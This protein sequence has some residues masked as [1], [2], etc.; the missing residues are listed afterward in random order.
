MFE[1]DESALWDAAYANVGDIATWCRL[2]EHLRATGRHRE[3]AGLHVIHESLRRQ[4]AEAFARLPTAQRLV[5]VPPGSDED[6]FFNWIEQNPHD[7][8]P[9]LIFADWLDDHG[10][11]DRAAAW[12]KSA[13][14]P[15]PRPY[16]GPWPPPL[17]CE[18]TA[19]V[20]RA[21]AAERGHVA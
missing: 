3:A 17:P 8:A 12:R 6:A 1:S 14:W 2:R 21:I 5:D 11:S 15:E 18:R 13:G 16:R 20:L 9:R 10:E 19:H 4:C 7:M